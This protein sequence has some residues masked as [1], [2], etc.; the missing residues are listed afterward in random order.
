MRRTAQLKQETISMKPFRDAILVIAVLA[1][2]A[3]TSISVDETR[4][5]GPE[6]TAAVQNEPLAS[7]AFRSAE[8]GHHVDK[9]ECP[10]AESQT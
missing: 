8:V 5:V 6:T 3:T 1:I 4:P 7:P 2:A 10:G 9:P